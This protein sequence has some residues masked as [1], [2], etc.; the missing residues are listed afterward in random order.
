[1]QVN[2]SDGQW[3]AVV[4][5][6]KK[7]LGIIQ[8]DG[9]T[10]VRVTADP[11][12][13]ILNSNG[14][15]WIGKPLYFQIDTLYEGDALFILFSIEMAVGGSTSLPSGLPSPYYEGFTGCIDHVKVDRHH[16]DW[17]RHGDNAILHY[18]DDT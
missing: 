17:H 8:V 18:C 15:L 6:R 3:H 11:G 9:E 2:V 5:E 13:T 1:L 10:A 7:R 14:K 12:A 16:L 4:V